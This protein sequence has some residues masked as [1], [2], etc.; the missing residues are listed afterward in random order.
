MTE[1]CKLAIGP[2][3]FVRIT[4]FVNAYYMCL[5]SLLLLDA[6]VPVDPV[7][8]ALGLFG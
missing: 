3:C 1:E 5:V 7:P 8:R 4:S 2:A 6:I